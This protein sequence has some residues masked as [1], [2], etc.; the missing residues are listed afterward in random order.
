MGR[1]GESLHPSSLPFSFLLP[2]NAVKKITA[3]MRNFVNLLPR[4]QQ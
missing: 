4:A 2:K 1:R 3:W